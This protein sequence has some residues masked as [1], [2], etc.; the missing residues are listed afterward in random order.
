MTSIKP[1]PVPGTSARCT[2]KPPRSRRPAVRD[3]LAALLVA[4]AL[5]SASAAFAQSPPDDAAFPT[6]ELRASASSQVAND[7]MVVRL[8]AQAS[9]TDMGALNGTV[10]SALNDALDRSKAVNGVSARLGSVTTQPEWDAQGKRT[11]W[12]VHGVLVLEGSDMAALGALAGRLGADL[13]IESVEFRL[14]AARRGVEENRLLKE[15]ADAFRERATKTATAFGYGGYE[16]RRITVLTQASRPTPPMPMA[17]MARGAELRSDLPAEG[18][19]ATVEIAIE[20][21]VRLTR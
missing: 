16:L 6:V 5:P 17:A 14:T 11:G 1:H 15:A 10:L 18:G 4:I 8:G 20:G 9:G 19:V 3:A 13:S 21:S 7:E 2:A 12:R